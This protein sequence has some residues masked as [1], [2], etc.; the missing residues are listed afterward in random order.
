MNGP[1]PTSDALDILIK[2]AIARKQYR[3]ALEL[4]ARHFGPRLGRLCLAIVGN[5][6]EAEE[7]V[8]E[9]L[10]AAHAAM[11]GFEGRSPL[12][13]W[14]YTIA[15]RAC[16]HHLDKRNRRLRLL[17][18]SVSVP[19]PAPSA[20]PCEQ[21]LARDQGERL[22]HAVAELPDGA[23]EVVLLRYSAGLSFR[24]V[25]EACGIREEAA[26]QRASAGLRQLRRKLAVGEA[27]VLADEVEREPMVQEVIR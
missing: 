3:R 8:Q 11:P 13:P 21:A 16:G 15:R 2:Q 26:R 24:E 4:L 12:R 7:L 23:R 10:L 6:A 27:E 19:L 9:V 20:D 5:Q 18:S 14:L 1:S 25:A 17:Q 22:R